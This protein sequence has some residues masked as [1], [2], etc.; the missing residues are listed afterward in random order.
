MIVRDVMQTEMV[1]IQAD[2]TLPDAVIK[3]GTLEARRLLVVDGKRLVGL[4]TSGEI[5]QTLQKSSGPQTP[6]GIVFQ[7]AFTH[8][9][10]IMTHQVYTV[11][12]TDDLQVAIHS[13]LEHH[14][15]GLPVLGEGDVLSG[16]LTLTDVLKA[17]ARDPQ[18]GWGLVRDHM[19]AGVLSVTPE[20][21][22]SAAAARLTVTRLRVMPVTKG[23]G[24]EPFSTGSRALLGVLYQRDI[25]A[26]IIHAEDGHGPTVLG[27]RFFLGNLTVRDMM[28]PP[29]NEI[30]V[31]AKVTEAVQAMQM[32]D[33]Y[34]L[35][36]VGHDG[37]LLGVITVSDILRLMVGG[38][39]TASEISAVSTRPQAETNG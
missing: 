15:G 33:V 29:K 28:R 14:V 27:D 10:D 7:A 4:L 20:M 22:L 37:D 36:V 9:R 8:V 25:R 30:L 12:E 19:S 6:W 1:T 34:G 35:P 32:A 24:D 11:L 2:Q 18:P 16:M 3:M 38:T 21:P 17:A 26:A 39:S 5:T 31:D 23:P 13:M